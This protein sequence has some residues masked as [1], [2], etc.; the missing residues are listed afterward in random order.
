M[1]DLF[2]TFKTRI[3]MQ[4]IK[5]HEAPVLQRPFHPP[6]HNYSAAPSMSGYSHRDHD[7]APGGSKYF[8]EESAG[9]RPPRRDFRDRAP[10]ASFEYQ[11]N[12]ESGRYQFGGSLPPSPASSRSANSMN[13]FSNG[14]QSLNPSSNS[15]PHQQPNSLGRGKRLDL[16][17][18]LYGDESS[19]PL[20]EAPMHSSASLSPSSAEVAARLLAGRTNSGASPSNQ[21]VSPSGSRGSSSRGAF[22]FEEMPMQHGS[23]NVDARL[24]HWE[25]QRHHHCDQGRDRHHYEMT[26]E[27]G[28]SGDSALDS[29]MSSLSVSAKPYVFQGSAHSN[30]QSYM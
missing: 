19:L 25:Q 2:A 22:N 16:D 26:R 4:K 20:G 8:P 23:A 9:W 14:P 18:S 1:R 13:I 21:Q 30:P 7:H 3:W 28:A 10:V 11:E 5:S 17:P 29:G 12:G 15:F 6:E 27:G 24:A